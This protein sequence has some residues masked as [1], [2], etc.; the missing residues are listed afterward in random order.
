MSKILDL[1]DGAVAVSYEER[2]AWVYLVAVVATFAGYVAVVLGRAGG[3]AL[4]DADYVAPLLWSLGI[5]IAVT[6]VGRTVVEIVR[7]GDGTTADVRD[8]EI[9]RSGDYVTGMVVG[10]GVLLPLALALIE[11]DYFWIA[12]SIYAVSALA[13]VVGTAVKLVMYRRGF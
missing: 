2:G 12:N 6:I 8:K 1:R 13:A 5:S 4:A 3:G 7:P 10:F 11:A 9:A